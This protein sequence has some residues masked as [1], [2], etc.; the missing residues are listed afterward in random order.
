[1]DPYDVV[2]IGAGHNGL[3]CATYLARAGLSVVVLE[4]SERIG[5]ACVTEELWPGFKVSTAAQTLTSL[6]PRLAAELDLKLEIRPKDPSLH[7]ALD[8]GGSVVVWSDHDKTRDSIA[9]LSKKD[10]SAYGD[11]V[12]LFAEAGK[13][14]RPLLS[15]PATRKQARRA[16][17]GSPFENLFKRTVDSSIAEVCESFFSDER[18]SG[19]IAGRAITGTTAGPR[20][21]GTAYLYLLGSYGASCGYPGGYVAGGMGAVTDALAEGAR[22][23]GVEIRTGAAVERIVVSDRRR[24]SGVVLTEGD[25]IPARAV[26]SNADPKRTLGLLSEEEL[27]PE[28]AEDIELLPTDGSVAVVHCALNGLPRAAGDGTSELAATVMVSPSIDYGERA[29]RDAAE[30]K[31]SREPVVRAHL[32]SASDPSLAPE[33]R[34]ILSVMAYYVPY[35]LAGEQWDGARDAFGD[36][37][38]TTLERAFPGLADLVEERLVLGPRDIEE[39]FGITG[40]HPNHGEMLPDWSFEK[41]PATGWHRHR[42][43]LVGLYLCG[44]GTHPGG[45]VSGLPGRNAARA[46]LSDGVASGGWS[47]IPG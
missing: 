2:I 45:G 5:G 19:A 29:C 30:R 26:I 25:E 21:P 6:D 3:T 23:A 41:R 47:P 13:R 40:G 9:R 16:F 43:P 38:I 14:L 33:G 34:H 35:E 42:T 18:V 20:T 15:Y 4:R 7:S 44:A 8:D 36:T 1:M 24:A 31:P 46:L 37:V 10:A 12:E 22:A 27:S 32:P 11:F 17:R 28:F 39:R